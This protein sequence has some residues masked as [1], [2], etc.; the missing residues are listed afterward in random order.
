[1]SGDL[2]ITGAFWRAQ[3]LL[4]ADSFAATRKKER[5]R[6]PWDD[7]SRHSSLWSGRLTSTLLPHR[8]RRAIL[9]EVRRLHPCSAWL[10]PRL[11][12]GRKL[13]R[14]GALALL[15]QALPSS[16]YGSGSHHVIGYPLGLH[17]FSYHTWAVGIEVRV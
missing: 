3:W 2:N 9:A 17:N 7:A 1:M 12:W 16:Y 8:R 5:E 15:L 6:R 4:L 11:W 14:P 10:E 13:P